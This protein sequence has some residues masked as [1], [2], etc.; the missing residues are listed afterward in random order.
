[1]RRARTR[2]RSA[3][4]AAT[5]ALVAV[6]LV[7][8]CGGDDGP[9]AQPDPSG[10][11]FV[12]QSFDELPLP[13]RARPLGPVQQED[14]GLSRTWGVRNTTAEEVLDFYDR[15][16]DERWEQRWPVRQVGD[17]YRG[18]WRDGGTRLRVSSVRAPTASGE[19]A[20]PDAPVVQLSLQLLPDG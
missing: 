2:I 15:N 16:L 7:A 5:S 14:E 3:L 4:R 19:P 10:T 8:A 11:G 17:G 1:M 13:P 18:E 9:E 12:E 20:A 6:L